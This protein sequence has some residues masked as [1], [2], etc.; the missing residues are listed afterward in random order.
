MT[1]DES[2]D[3]KISPEGL[4]YYKTT[5]LLNIPSVGAEPVSHLPNSLNGKDEDHEEMLDGDTEHPS[6]V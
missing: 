4:K 2:K 6:K 3:N 5:S 1:A